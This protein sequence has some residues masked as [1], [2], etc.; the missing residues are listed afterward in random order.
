MQLTA[1]DISVDRYAFPLQQLPVRQIS[2]L[3]LTDHFLKF[4]TPQCTKVDGAKLRNLG[5]KC[6]SRV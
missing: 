3:V 5:C 6:T 1:I 2:V 4:G